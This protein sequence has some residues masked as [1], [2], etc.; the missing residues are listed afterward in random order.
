[1]R[2]SVI[3]AWQINYLD[4]EEDVGGVWGIGPGSE[5]PKKVKEEH[6]V[7]TKVTAFVLRQKEGPSAC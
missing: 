7:A 3:H 4:H 2:W 5:I 1:M 6:A